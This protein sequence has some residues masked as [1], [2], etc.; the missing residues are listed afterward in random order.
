MNVQFSK[1]FINEEYKIKKLIKFL[2]SSKIDIMFLQNFNQRKLSEVM[3]KI[4]SYRVA[5]LE[6]IH[7][8][9]LFSWNWFGKV[10]PDDTLK[11]LKYYNNIHFSME[12]L[13]QM[14]LLFKSQ[15]EI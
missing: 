3:K 7:S 8:L 12:E 2:K 11:P 10:W 9:I 6:G 13:E 4:E 1:N 15:R 14:R 5:Y